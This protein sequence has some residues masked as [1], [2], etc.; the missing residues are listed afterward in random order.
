MICDAELEVSP[1]EVPLLKAHRQQPRRQV[2]TQRAGGILL[3]HLTH[4]WPSER[5]AND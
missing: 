4:S 1:L 2:A 3:R 5:C